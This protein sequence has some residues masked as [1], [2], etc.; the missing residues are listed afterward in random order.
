MCGQRSLT[1]SHILH[2]DLPGLIFD[3]KHVVRQARVDTPHGE[4]RCMFKPGLWNV[5]RIRSEHGK[6]LAGSRKSVPNM[7]ARTASTRRLTWCY[8]SNTTFHIHSTA[9]TK[10]RV[11][12]NLREQYDGIPFQQILFDL[13]AAGL[14][15]KVLVDKLHL[16]RVIFIA[17]AASLPSVR[18]PPRPRECKT[19]RG[20]LGV[21]QVDFA[22]FVGILQHEN[23]ELVIDG[24]R[25]APNAHL[26]GHTHFGRNRNNT[27][28]LA[29]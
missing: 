23:P 6:R 9:T 10:P 27:Q 7:H 24:E 12:T 18:R 29:A 8:M 4:R 28:S 11:M 16:L 3:A 17:F 14:V 20:I 21:K 2:R 15:R 19:R 5:R 22:V 1:R 26:D 25:P 13:F